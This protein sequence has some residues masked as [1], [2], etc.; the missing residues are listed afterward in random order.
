M[1]FRPED[2][3]TALELLDRPFI[4]EDRTNE[5]FETETLQT[6]QSSIRP[7]VNYWEQGGEGRFLNVGNA[8]QPQTSN[9]SVNS[10][11]FNTLQ[12][13]TKEFQFASKEFPSMGKLKTNEF[14]KAEFN[15]SPANMRKS[16]VLNNL[17]QN[18]IK[19]LPDEE[20]TPINNNL[21]SGFGKG[22]SKDNIEH[23]QLDAEKLKELERIKAEKRRKWELEMQNELNRINSDKLKETLE[24]LGNSGKL[25]KKKT[26]I[27]QKDIEE[28]ERIKAEKRRK[29]E[30]EMEHALARIDTNKLVESQVKTK[31]AEEEIAQSQIE[32]AKEEEERLERIRM[33]KRKKWEEEM[34]NELKRISTDKL[35]EAL[36]DV[37]GIKHTEDESQPSINR[38]KGF[39][40]K[41]I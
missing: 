18:A 29:W 11:N 31:T 30:E 8:Y 32:L 40:A 24:E 19:E 9:I 36:A 38:I 41:V 12:T 25:E 15:H 39:Q 3:P 28:L 33:E 22:Q 37:S 6:M 27:M 35:R 13:N 5:S 20:S 1:K 17:R 23:N 4:R 14:E 7:N 21:I 16:A 26:Q 34:Q 2:R 10:I